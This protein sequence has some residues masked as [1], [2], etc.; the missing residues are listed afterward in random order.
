MENESKK[1]CEEF[2]LASESEA[3]KEYRCLNRDF[4]Y[5]NYPLIADEII[6]NLRR[7]KPRIL[8]VGTGL[9]SLAREFATR[10]PACCVYGIDISDE[11]LAEAQAINT[12]ETVSNLTL[13]CSDINRLP[14]ADETFDGIVSFGVLH[15]LSAVTHAFSEIRRV[16]RQGGEAFLYDLRNNPPG[17]IVSEIATEMPPSQARAFL[18]SVKEGLDVSHIEAV[19]KSLGVTRYSL[20]CPAY[21][22]ATIVKNKSVLQASRFLGKRFNQLLVMIYLQK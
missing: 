8:D 3:V 19:V 6:A 11:M 17:E 18:E 5:S 14:F 1:I 15:H 13:M 12:T 7:E 22:R 16:L 10:L 9:G 2:G 4:M 20:S 21:S